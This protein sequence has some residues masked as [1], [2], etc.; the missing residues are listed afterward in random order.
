M[1]LYALIGIMGSA[2]IA[3]RPHPRAFYM[4]GYLLS[5][6]LTAPHVAQMN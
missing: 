6:L 1:T 4:S 3:A 2:I 5:T